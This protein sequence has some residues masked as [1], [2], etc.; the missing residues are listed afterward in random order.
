VAQA[1]S[2]RFVAIDFE[3]TGLS[4]AN[5]EII[6]FGAV[7]V[8][9]GK[10]VERFE[11]LAR[12][13]E[14][15]PDAVARLTGISDKELSEAPDHGHALAEF[16]EF[17]GD[18][19]LVAH[20]ASFEAGFL[21]AATG[22]HFSAEILDSLEL[23]R[24]VLPEAP[25]HALGKLAAGLGLEHERLHRAAADAELGA[26]LW[27]A[28]LEKLHALP[29]PVLS[30]ICWM[31]GLVA[32]PLK[33]LF[34]QAEKAAVADL[35]KGE[36]EYAAL[37]GTAVKGTREPFEPGDPQELGAGDLAAELDA[38]GAVANSL[39][40]Y[41]A[42]PQQL[43]MCREVAEAFNAGRHLVVEAG[44]GVG[45][46]LA[47]LLPAAAWSESGA[48]KVI[49]STNTKNL[50]SQ[51]FGKDIPL[52]EKALGRKLDAA[53]L[54]GR[55]NYLCL[56]KLLYILREAG[57][58]LDDVGREAIL[59]VL[60]WAA[61]T[62]SGDIAECPPLFLRDAL[63]LV[64]KLTTDGPDCLGRGC[65][66]RRKCFLM[67]ARAKA[68]AAKIIVVNHSLVFAELGENMVLPPYG[69]I[70]F[71]EAHNLEGVATR[72]LSARI[73]PGRFYRVLNRLLK[74]RARRRR[75]KRRRASGADEGS[76]T[77]LLPSLSEQ[78]RR[79]HGEAAEGFLEK[80]EKE[81]SE[82]SSQVELA[83]D[84][85]ITFNAALTGLW[86]ASRY[87][88]KLSYTRDDR[89]M[90]LWAAVF[91]AKD[92]LVAVLSALQ[93]RTGSIAE[94][95]IEDPDADKLLRAEEL[96]RELS[97]A[98]EQLRSL[99]EDIDFTVKA[100]DE[101]YV[102]WAELSG[103]GGD[104]PELSAAPLDVAPMLAEQVYGQKR[105]CVLCSATMTVAKK[106]DYLTSRLGLDR[107]EQGRVSTLLLG[108]PFDYSTQARALVPG[109]LP[110][111]GNAQSGRNS[112]ELAEM[113]YELMSATRGRGLVLFTSYG[114]LDEVYNEVKPRL[115]AEGISVLAQGRDGS[116]EA[117]L[118]ALQ[119]EH[120]SVLLATSSFWEGIDV[121]GAAL[122][123]LVITRL[124]FQVYT[125][126]LFKARAELV[127]SHGESSFMNYSVPEAVLKFRQGFGRLIRSK[128][129]RGI[130]VLAD[131]RLVSKRYGRVFLAS[132]PC[133]Y[134]VVSNSDALARAAEQF[135]GE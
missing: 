105:S 81:I 78:L 61:R 96:G 97:A 34:I 33:D 73:W 46:S 76:G 51:L 99:L 22:Q 45:K 90:D 133:P 27:L 2:D 54:K 55:G 53:L 35:G 10:V 66:Q 44:T 79:A 38:G 8:A 6:E 128:T 3:T 42:R 131:R 115:E 29:L 67:A 59:P 56:R 43:E 110:E 26:R 120:S 28:L 48:R 98:V 30:E 50:Q 1:T 86:G 13:S 31:L 4:H 95:L 100:E 134:R 104:Q 108:T 82:S 113:L 103:R 58:E 63:G 111:P 15:L 101:R 130:A 11:M 89:R 23:A 72:H 40:D 37:F 123:C 83:V 9:D 14:P 91:N 5:C 119:E 84:A 36:P 16:L 75:G 132:L 19:H 77:G 129:D 52:L 32:H 41:E 24:I 21:R 116:R 20:N 114:A 135:F 49:I 121:R 71:D 126:P 12:P 92:E 85:L 69:E 127:E 109:W 47:Y 106:F 74:F 118:T 107:Q 112:A 124:P 7:R 18:D 117:L 68:Q 102:Y 80:L 17:I 88:D 70:I 87:R 94:S 39:S 25:S 62:A 65:K 122:S 64:D 93:S 125:E 60:V 57:S